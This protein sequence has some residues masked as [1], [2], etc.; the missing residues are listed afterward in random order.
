[1]D[2]STWPGVSSAAGASYSRIHQIVQTSP[3]APVA[4]KTQRQLARP[5]MAAIA[6]GATTAP[7]AVPALIIPMAV[8]RSLAGNHSDTAFVAAVWIAFWRALLT[9]GAQGH[10]PLAVLTS[11]FSPPFG[12]RPILLMGH[13]DTVFP[14]GEPSRRPFKIEGDRAYGPGVIH[15]TAHPHYAWVIRVTGTDLDKL[16]RYHFGKKD[17][18]LE[19]A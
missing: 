11:T 8:D 12:N 3:V 14:K 1:M 13:R 16:A 15:S 18:I 5:R 17:K 19:R 6:G 4:K 10:P 2:V 9:S 7:T